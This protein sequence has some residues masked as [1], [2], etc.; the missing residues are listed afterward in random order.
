MKTHNRQCLASA[1]PRKWTVDPD[2]SGLRFAQPWTVDRA[3][4]RQWL[5]SSN[6]RTARS[7]QCTNARISLENRNS[8][9]LLG[10][11]GAPSRRQ[12]R[13]SMSLQQHEIGLEACPPRRP[14][15]LVAGVPE[16][17]N[18]EFRLCFT[19]YARNSLHRRA[20]RHDQ[21]TSFQWN[22]PALPWTT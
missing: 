16:N 14:R 17:C 1:T 22:D 9:Q 8:L 21:K 18:I 11:L 7:D 13:L 5:A 3:H 20:E 2:G 15:N 10:T 6:P 4:D 19:S 12:S